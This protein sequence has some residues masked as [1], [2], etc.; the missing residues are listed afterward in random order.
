MATAKRSIAFD[1]AVLSEAERLAGDTTGDLSAFVNAAVLREVRQ[2]RPRARGEYGDAGIEHYREAYLGALLDRDARRARGIAEV[3][4]ESGVPIGD[5]YAEIFQPVL[6]QVGHLWAMEEIN[7]AQEHFATNTTQVLLSTL[8]P[9][10]RSEPTEGR[11]AIVSATPG[12]LHL[13]GAQMAADLLER[14]GWEVMSLGA[15][16]PSRDLVELV[17]LEQPDVVALSAATA[18]RL[19]GVEEVLRLL[20]GVKPKPFVVVGGTLFTREAAEHAMSLGADLILSDVRELVPVVRERF[21]P[22]DEEA[23]G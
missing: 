5:L 3:A 2:Y 16:T 7:V 23:H 14:A 1:A 21:P 15:S 8:A 19:P 17:E 18:G 9:A 12:E 10:L 6:E 13:V 4:V 20:G 22:V 11:L